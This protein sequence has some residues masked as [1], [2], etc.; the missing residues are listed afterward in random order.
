MVEANRSM[1]PEVPAFKEGIGDIDVKA[2]DKYLKDAGDPLNLFMKAIAS[3]GSNKIT[4]KEYS[5]VMRM[6]NRAIEG[7]QYNLPTGSVWAL[8]EALET[9]L[10]S[11][12]GK[13]TKDNLL[14][15]EALKEG[16]EAMVAQSGK[17]FDG[18]CK[19]TIN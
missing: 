11:F 7:T 14:S 12:G 18:F 9:D 8:R 15:D 13:L 4:P 1:L 2:I 3:I 16:Y 10:N 6:L 19:I 17:E 5:G